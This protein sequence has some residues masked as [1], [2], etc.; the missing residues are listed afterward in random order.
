MKEAGRNAP[1]V[2][3]A[4]DHHAAFPWPH[5]KIAHRFARDKLY[6][7]C[8]PFE[9]SFTTTNSER[10]PRNYRR[11]RVALMHRKRVHHPA[12]DLWVGIHVGRGNIAIRSNQDRDFRRVAT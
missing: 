8:S 5:A 11:H 4:L 12:H 10:F 9:T 6:S 2:A 1:D 3:K 7:A